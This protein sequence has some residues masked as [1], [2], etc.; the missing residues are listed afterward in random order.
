MI[1][2]CKEGYIHEH[3]NAIRNEVIKYLGLYFVKELLQT[4]A[5]RTYGASLNR[6]HFPGCETEIFDTREYWR[7]YVQH[8]TLTS[9]HPAGTCRIGDVVDATFR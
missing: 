9:Y 4:S 6:K 8:L 3:N 5:L 7:C 1:F 2:K